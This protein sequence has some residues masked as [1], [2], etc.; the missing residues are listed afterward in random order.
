MDR[1]QAGKKRGEWIITCAQYPFGLETVDL[2]NIF[3]APY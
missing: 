2:E 3:N 1:V